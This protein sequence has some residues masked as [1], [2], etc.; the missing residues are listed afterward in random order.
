MSQNSLR[1]PLN[2]LF[3]DIFEMVLAEQLLL[4]VLP[5]FFSVFMFQL[6]I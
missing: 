3:L 5:D 4:Y 2:L 1:P 6:I